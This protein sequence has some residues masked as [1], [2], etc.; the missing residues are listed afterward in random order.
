MLLTLLYEA[1]ASPLGIV[2]QTTDP[3]RT[4]MALYAERRKRADPALSALA[5][6]LPP[7]STS[8][9]WLVRKP[10]TDATP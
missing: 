2:V 9:L 8:E 7:F 10:T 5:I 6:C 3:E 4:R 1:L